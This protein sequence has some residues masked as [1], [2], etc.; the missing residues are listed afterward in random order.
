M[1]KGLGK[2]EQEIL[3]QLR[4]RY[5]ARMVMNSYINRGYCTRTILGFAFGKRYQHLSRAEN[6]SAKRTLKRLT[7][8]GYLRQDRDTY[9]LTHYT[10][11]SEFFNYWSRNA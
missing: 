8:K 7:E 10:R 5:M 3:E 9:H 11:E 1:S 4:R 6:V 2:V